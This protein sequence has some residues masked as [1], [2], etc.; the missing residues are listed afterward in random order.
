MYLSL[1]GNGFTN[2]VSTYYMIIKCLVEEA[3]I[4]DR[5]NVLDGLEDLMSW[6]EDD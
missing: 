1:S 4:A 3:E 5:I 6:E 2:S